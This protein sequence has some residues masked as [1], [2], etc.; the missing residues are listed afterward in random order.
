MG[1]NLFTLPNPSAVTF[2]RINTDNT[3]SALTASAFRT[4]IGAGT[5]STVGTVTSIDLIAG[6]TGTDI[7]ISGGPITSTGSITINIPDASASARGVVTTSSQTFSGGKTFRDNISVNSVSIGSP[8]GGSQNTMFGEVSFGYSTPG[9]NN[10]GLG[11]FTLAT[12]DGGSDNT[13]VGTNAIRQG[14]ASNGSRNTAVGSHALSNGSASQDNVAIG[15]STLNGS[16]GSGNIAIGT[17]ALFYA[18]DAAENIGIG[19]YAL[20]HATR[21]YNTSVGA[22]SMFKNTLGDVNVAVGHKSLFENTTGRYNTSLGVQSLEQNTTGF[23]NTAVGVAA[24]DQNIS[25]SYNAVMGAFAGRYFGVSPSYGNPASFASSINYSVI[26][27][28]DARPLANNSSN[29]IVIGYNAVGNGD[30]TIQL[31]NSS[32]TSVKTSG[33]IT[34]ASFIKS[35]GTS[36]QFLMADGSATTS[37]SLTNATAL[38][39]TSGVSGILPVANGGTGVISSTGSGNVVLSTS[40]SLTTPSLGVATATSINNV[41]ITAATTSSTLTI[42][43][44]KALTISNTLTFAGTDGTAMTFPSSNATV[45]SLAGAETLTNKTINGSNNTINNISLT[46]AVTGILPV[47]NG[48]TG[49]S[50]FSNGELLIGSTVSNTLTKSTLTA[51]AGITI[52]NGGGS[53]TIASSSPLPTSNT[54]GDMLYWNGSAWV[55]VAAGADGQVLTFINGVPTWTVAQNPVI[56]TVVGAGG[57]VWMDRNLGASQVATS[58]GDA[59]AYGDLYQWGRGPDG[60]QIR[61]SGTTGLISSTDKPGHGNFILVYSSPVDWRSGQNGNLWQGVNGINNPCPIGFRIPTQAEWDTEKASWSAATTGVGAWSS[62]LKLPMAGMRLN[63]DNASTNNGVLWHEGSRGYYWS[64]TITGTNSFRL[65][66][67][68]NF[69]PTDNTFRGE[70]NSVRCIKD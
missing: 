1:G 52:T 44:G 28:A 36:S 53:I 30:N 60:H 8:S 6:T 65:A 63:D 64:S 15:V 67:S 7:S 35:G 50:S 25:G 26:I 49:Q 56:P 45:A 27:G 62:P 4:A 14:G 48:G 37:P 54:A 9:N 47:A 39:L 33:T 55:K 43:N 3:V 34:G 70:G 46:S 2:P 20:H 59:A 17:N 68:D 23:H 13:A 57:R 38:P 18:T 5:S 11:F 22:Y 69:S 10:T 61:T 21:G 12:L 16:T 24:I 29:E 58:S 31:G 19:Y 41:T 40:P 66:F 42:A 51:G 32:I